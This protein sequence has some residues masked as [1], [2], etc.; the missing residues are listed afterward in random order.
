MLHLDI[1]L[2]KGESMPVPLF[3]SSFLQETLQASEV[4][5][6]SVTLGNGVQMSL[7]KKG[8]LKISP[9]SEAKPSKHMVISSAVHLTPS[10]TPRL[11]AITRGLKFGAK[12]LSPR[13]IAPGSLRPS[14]A[15]C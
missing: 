8:V 6:R 1:R 4:S 3:E 13:V 11:G 10:K 14:T 15:V 12:R 5:P 2:R 9:P 7:L